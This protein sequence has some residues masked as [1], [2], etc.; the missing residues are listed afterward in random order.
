MSIIQIVDKADMS[1]LLS[2]KNEFKLPG[3]GEMVTG[4]VVNVSKSRIVVDIENAA[5]GVIMGTEAHDSTNTLKSINVGDEVKATIIAPENKDGYVVLSLRQASQGRTWDRFVH[6]FKTQEKFA[7]TVREANKGGLLVEEDGIRGFIPVSQ[8]A[9]ENYP[10]VPGGNAAR[11]LERLQSLVG[12]KLEVCVINIDESEGRMILSEKAA[13]RE[14][15]DKIMHEVQPGKILKGKISGVVDF[16]V[17]VNYHGVEGLVHISEIDWGHVSNPADYAEIGKEV[18]VLVIGVEGDKISF[19]M[20]RL[21]PDPWL[22]QIQKYKMGEKVSGTIN[23]VTEYGV[24]VKL[25]E[26]I[27][28]LVHTSELSDDLENPNP[29]DVVKVGQEVMCT[30]INIDQDKHEIGLSLRKKPKKAVEV[31]EEVKE[32]DEKVKAKSKE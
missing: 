26:N 24:F 4:I 12:K 25:D 5:M 9:P 32:E 8:L 2:K 17:F 14:E 21:T 29:D 22:D 6:S 13:R 28:G 27:S 15:R 1:T 7:I 11:I 19:S 10:R 30:I 16:G 31:K 20:K 18:E 3:V 23:K